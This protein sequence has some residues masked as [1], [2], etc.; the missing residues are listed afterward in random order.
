[1]SKEDM[2]KVALTITDG[3]ACDCEA[4]TNPGKSTL[5]MG[6]KQGDRYVITYISDWSKN[7]EFKRAIRAIRKGHDCK[8][9]IEEIA[10]QTDAN[11]GGL[12]TGSKPGG[13][14][15]V[16]IG[17]E[18]IVDSDKKG[19]DR[20]KN[21]SNKKNKNKKGKKNK[22]KSNK[23][24][25]GKSEEPPPKIGWYNRSILLPNNYFYVLQ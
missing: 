17:G 22:N 24:N 16:S 2:K 3:S 14:V 10:G 4:V 6:S 19:K 7:K 1:M 23:E 12:S 8:K 18:V 21:R 11:N 15:D 13:D 25:G 20:N 9:Q 5:V